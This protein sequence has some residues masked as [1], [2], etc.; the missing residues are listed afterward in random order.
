MSKAKG[1]N[2]GTGETIADRLSLGR[3]VREFKLGSS[4]Q[5][6]ESSYHTVRYDFKSNAIDSEMPSSMEIGKNNE[7]TVNVPH[8]DKNNAPAQTT[9]KGSKKPYLKECVFI[10]DH[11]TGE[12]TLEK[13]S[14]NIQLKKTRSESLNVNKF[15]NNR[16]STP[17]ESEF[18]KSDER[19]EKKS[20]KHSSAS[21]RDANLP[22]NRSWNKS[23]TKHA[24]NK[25]SELMPSSSKQNTKS[26]TPSALLLP[27]VKSTASNNVGTLSESSSDSSDSSSDSESDFES[28]QWKGNEAPTKSPSEGH[29]SDSDSDI[30]D[31]GRRS[32]QDLKTAQRAAQ[33]HPSQKPQSSTKDVEEQKL[34]NELF[35]SMPPLLSEDLQLSES[36]SDSD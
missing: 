22:D 35:P 9:F 17:N 25:S 34:K 31:A 14:N 4:F 30:G 1:S 18:S 36:G 8:L 29:L 20:S 33:H 23:S 11:N 10:I 32:H 27:P 6:G 12:I 15:T 19:K 13:L 24:D 21:N 2:R 16:P 7:I 3:E 26:I 28:P 5:G